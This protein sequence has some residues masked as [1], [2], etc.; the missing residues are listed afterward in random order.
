MS[1]WDKFYTM[2]LGRARKTFSDAAGVSACMTGQSLKYVSGQIDFVFGAVD[3]RHVNVFEVFRRRGVSDRCRIGGTWCQRGEE[4]DCN[5]GGAKQ[6]Q[7][8]NS[9]P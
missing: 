9:R 2:M 4:G 6:I 5:Q 8:S 7:R 1:C 3:K